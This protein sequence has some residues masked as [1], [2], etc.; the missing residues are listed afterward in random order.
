LFPRKSSKPKK[1]DTPK[2]EQKGETVTK[3]GS[4]L[5]S[6]TGFS[7]IK[8]SA[9]PKPVEGGAYVKL[10]MA[11]SEARYLGAKEKREKDKADAEAAKK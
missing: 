4:S 11:R 3:I 2:A 7:E 6:I 8:K 1:G 9:V 10:R 5:P